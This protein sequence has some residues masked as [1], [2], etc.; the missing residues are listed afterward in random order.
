MLL[1][2]VIEIGD[3][4]EA[5][6]PAAS[7]IEAFSYR[8]APDGK[9]GLYRMDRAYKNWLKTQ[10]A[11]VQGNLKLKNV[12]VTDIS[13]FYARINFHRLENLLDE[14]A[15]NHGAARYIKKHIKVI[16]AK[17]SFGLPVGG[18]AARLLAELALTDTDRA[19]QQDGRLATRFVDDFRIFLRPDENPYDALAFIAEQLGINEGLSLNVSKTTV[20]SRAEFLSRLKHLVTDVSDEAEGAALETLTSDLYFDDEPD[21]EE[22]EKLKSMNLL[23]FLQEEVGKEAFDMGRIKVIFRALKIAKPTDAIVYLS[24]NFSELVVFAKEMT[25]LMQVLEAENSGCFDLLSDTVIDAILAPPASSIQLIK[26]WL[27]ELFVRGTVPI[28]AAGIKKLNVLSSPLDRRQRHLI[29]GRSRDKNFFRKNKT[30]FGQLSA[31]EQPCFIWG[32]SCLPEDEYETWLSTAKPMFTAPTGALFL[33]WAQQ[34]RSK[35]ISKLDVS[36]DDHQE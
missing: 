8:F 33:K 14:A 32:A 25:L 15:P 30:G 16:R 6:R 34:Q 18:S 28:T 1:A 3:L 10:V 19:L 2:A 4:I 17:Q 26:T 31:L 11:L 21:L 35:L 12:I 23:G 13:D 29:R 27:L 36:T 9:G 5:H 22:L 7:G 24:T 20:Y